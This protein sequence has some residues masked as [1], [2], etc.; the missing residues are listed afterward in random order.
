VFHL[1]MGL[2]NGSGD[3]WMGIMGAGAVLLLFRKQL[4]LWAILFHEL[5]R[6]AWPFLGNL[7][8]LVRGRMHAGMSGVR[9]D[10]NAV[11]RVIK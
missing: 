2:G 10:W 4:R 11:W 6:M 8:W 1:A 9:T 7:A 3:I 5:W